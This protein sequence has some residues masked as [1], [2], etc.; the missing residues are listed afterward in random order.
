M[1]ESGLYPPFAAIL[2]NDVQGELQTLGIPSTLLV[3]NIAEFIPYVFQLFAALLEAN[4]SGSLSEYY[5]SL[6]PPILDPAPWASKGN[7]PALV[8]LLS[9]IIPRGVTEI[10]QGDQLETLLG[11][12]QQLVATKTN[13]TYGFELLECVVNNFPP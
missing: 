7:V 9:A 5:R 13:E 6:I 11:V 8:R 12:F 2:Q 4:P 10:T 1:V 3:L